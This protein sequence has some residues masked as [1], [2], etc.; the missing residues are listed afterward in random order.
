VN[1]QA[2]GR[3]KIEAA[4]LADAIF[5]ELSTPGALIGG[6]DKA[7][8]RLAVKAALNRVRGDD[9]VGRG[10]EEHDGLPGYWVCERCGQPL[11]AGGCCNSG[12]HTGP[13]DDANGMAIH[14][15][16]L[17]AR[18]KRI[19]EWLYAIGDRQ[20]GIAGADVRGLAKAMEREFVHPAAGEQTARATTEAG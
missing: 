5:D 9:E 3:A 7:I 18:P 17:A 2:H 13:G 11:A 10:I 8:L 6:F 15:T 4:V 1:V 20:G 16:D 14:T 12:L 19:V